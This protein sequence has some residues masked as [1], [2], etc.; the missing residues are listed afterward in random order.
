MTLIDIQRAVNMT[1]EQLDAV[2]RQYAR[3]ILEGTEATGFSGQKIEDHEDAAEAIMYDFKNGYKSCLEKIC[4]TMGV[5]MSN[6]V[7]EP[8]TS[9]T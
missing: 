3:E 6:D 9:K 4:V 8:S 1:A 2:A 5:P 7:A